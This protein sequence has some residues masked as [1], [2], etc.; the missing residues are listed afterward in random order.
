[1]IIDLR[2]DTLTKPTGKMLEAMQNAMVGDDI[3]GEDPTIN[4]LEEKAAKMFGMEAAVFCASGTMCNQIGIKISTQ[5]GDELICHELAHI[6]NY[7]GGGIAFNSLV[8]TR[9]IMG[10]AGKILPHQIQENI[11]PDDQHFP[12]TSLVCLENTINKGGGGYYKI[13]EIEAISKICKQNNLSLHLDGARLFNALTET[14]DSTKAYG[15][16]FD[17]I[18]VCLSKGLGCPVGSILISSEKKIKKA[19]RIRKILG[20]A[21]RQAGYLAA[22]GIYALDN[23]IERLKEDHKRAKI[24]AQT[25]KEL[26]YVEAVFPQETNIVIF[27]LKEQKPSQDFLNELENE[28]IKASG[29]GPQIIRFVSHLDFDDSMLEKVVKVLKN[30]IQ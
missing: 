10:N 4:Q 24:L 19:R 2:S 30:K 12:N 16:Y 21:W 9:L 1:M 14:K 27:K 7:E 17:S 22:A 11:N 18:S 15:K 26:P 6:Y 29:M 5:P 23:H 3:Y 8:S 13:S 20:G 25:L 28:Q